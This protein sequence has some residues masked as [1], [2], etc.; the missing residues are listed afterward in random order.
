MTTRIVSYSELTTAR[1]CSLKHELAYVDRFSRPTD[2]MSALGKGSAWHQV[3]ETHYNVLKQ[4]QG[5]YRDEEVLIR[6]REAV[7]KDLEAMPP[8]LAQLIVWMYEG[9]VSL[10]GTDPGWK[11]LAVEHAAQIRLPTPRG[12]PSSF[13]LKMKIDL[14]VRERRTGHVRLVDHK[15]GKDLPGAKVLEMDDQFPLYVWGM[16]QLGRPVHSAYYS[17]ARTLRL[18]ADK[19]NPGA[20]PL[21]ER[22]S[23]IPMYLTDK[24]LAEVVRDAY[25]TARTRY[26]EQAMA[27]RLGI[28]SPRSPDPMSCQWQCD[29]FEPCMAGRKGIP[30]RPF[31]RDKGF[32][33]HPERH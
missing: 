28:D 15:S 9:Y 23:R 11:V 26:S 6:C 4:A 29:F 17:A 24:H 20:T 22:F 1:R 32:E 27:R 10:Y 12:T 8:D 19:K 31:L 21:D 3:L 16:R 25:L 18:E 33:S 30:I 2:P 14:V 7:H 5:H 13:Y